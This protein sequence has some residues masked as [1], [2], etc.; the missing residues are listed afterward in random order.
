MV[1]R[2]LQRVSIR[3]LEDEGVVLMFFLYC[4]NH[5][6]IRAIYNLA[7]RSELSKK[8]FRI[9]KKVMHKRCVILVPER[10]EDIN[11]EVVKEKLLFFSGYLVKTVLVPQPCLMFNLLRISLA[12]DVMVILVMVDVQV[13]LTDRFSDLAS[14][15]KKD[16]LLSKLAL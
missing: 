12:G 15:Q 11:F 16:V 3:G 5:N 6:N 4:S 13:A 1:F 7:W 10:V 2:V 8:I 14:C 9:L